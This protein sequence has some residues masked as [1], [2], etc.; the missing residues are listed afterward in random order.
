M[1]CID[2]IRPLDSVIMLAVTEKD[3]L[4]FV[5]KLEG[6]ATFTWGAAASRCPGF[7]EDFSLVAVRA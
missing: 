5:E 1:P 6:T 3:A 4:G 7:I 2:A